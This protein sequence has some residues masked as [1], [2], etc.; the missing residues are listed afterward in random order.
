MDIILRNIIKPK[1]RISAKIYRDA[2]FFTKK[3][4]K[5]LTF[6]LIGC[7]A[8]DCNFKGIVAVFCA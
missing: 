1:M 4:N 5:N 8:F 6:V 2:L 3:V 7:I